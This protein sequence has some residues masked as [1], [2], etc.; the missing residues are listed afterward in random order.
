MVNNAA[1][2]RA[3]RREPSCASPGVSLL[4]E[5]ESPRRAGKSPHGSELRFAGVSL[6]T[7][8]ELRSR[9]V[10]PPRSALCFAQS[11]SAHGE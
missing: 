4:T 3:L 2:A 6:L 11:V 9:A 5:S 1:L 8:S 10:S 7:A